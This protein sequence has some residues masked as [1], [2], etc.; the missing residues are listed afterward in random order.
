MSR[1]GWLHLKVGF[2]S[3]SHLILCYCW[4]YKILTMLQAAMVEASPLLLCHS[5]QEDLS[6]GAKI[7]EYF[8]KPLSPWISVCSG[9][10]LVVQIPCVIV[11][12]CK[13][14][15]QI[16]GYPMT[17]SLYNSAD[18]R[19]A[20]QVQKTFSSVPPDTGDILDT[21]AW[22]SFFKCLWVLCECSFCRRQSLYFRKWH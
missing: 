15:P 7:A 16:R 10:T 9:A 17:Y 18:F 22:I 21:Y 4:E 13:E 20:A 2:L 19:F 14:T 11:T 3:V 6:I 12:A 8:L 5:F 1:N